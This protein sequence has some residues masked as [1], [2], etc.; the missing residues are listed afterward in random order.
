MSIHRRRWSSWRLVRSA[1]DGEDQGHTDHV[2]IMPA[3][4][5][6]AHAGSVRTQGSTPI[7]PFSALR[8]CK[9]SNMVAASGRAKRTRF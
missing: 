6:Y 8:N 4:R 7:S 9:L 1:S 2:W 3:R 5:A